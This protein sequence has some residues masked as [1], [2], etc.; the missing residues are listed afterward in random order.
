[1]KHRCYFFYSLIGIAPIVSS[2]A[3]IYVAPH[4]NLKITSDK[5]SSEIK[6]DNQNQERD[7][8][9][10]AIQNFISL[11]KFNDSVDISINSKL[12]VETNEVQYDVADYLMG[13]KDM[14]LGLSEAILGLADKDGGVFVD[15]AN[16]TLD[17]VKNTY[18]SIS[19]PIVQAV[20]PNDKSSITINSDKKIQV[21]IS[22]DLSNVVLQSSQL[23][24]HNINIANGSGLDRPFTFPKTET[25]KFT[26]TLPTHLKISGNLNGS[27]NVS[28]GSSKAIFTGELKSLFQNLT[29]DIVLNFQDDIGNSQNGSYKFRDDSWNGSLGANNLTYKVNPSTSNI[30]VKDQKDNNFFDQILL[31]LDTNSCINIFNAIFS[32]ADNNEKDLLKKGN[33][34]FPWTNV[35]LKNG[36][37]P[38]LIKFNSNLKN[39]IEMGEISR[40]LTTATDLSLKLTPANGWPS[41]LNKFIILVKSYKFNNL[42]EIKSLFNRYYDKITLDQ[43]GSRTFVAEVEQLSNKY[44]SAPYKKIYDSTLNWLN[45][46]GL[47]SLFPTDE[48]LKNNYNLFPIAGLNDWYRLEYVS[49][50]ILGALISNDL[51]ATVTVKGPDNSVLAKEDGMKIFSSSS[52]SFTSYLSKVIGGY[53]NGEDGAIYKVSLN[54]FKICNNKK[55]KFL[56]FDSSLADSPKFKTLNAAGALS[57]VNIFYAPDAMH[58]SS[59]IE[60]NW[61]KNKGAIGVNYNKY[62]SEIISLENTDDHAMNEFTSQQ[63]LQDLNDIINGNYNYVDEKNNIIYEPRPISFSVSNEGMGSVALPIFDEVLCDI[64]TKSLNKVFNLDSLPWDKQ[65]FTK[66]EWENSWQKFDIKL[67]NESK[68]PLF[69]PKQSD[70]I[71]YAIAKIDSF[72]TKNCYKDVRSW[73]QNERTK[74][75]SWINKNSK[76]SK[77]GYFI[78]K[79]KAC[80]DR[81][82]DYDISQKRMYYVN[83]DEEN[84]SYN[85]SLD[86]FVKNALLKTDEENGGYKYLTRKSKNVNG[87]SNW[88]RSEEWDIDEWSFNANRFWNDLVNDPTSFESLEWTIKDAEKLKTYFTDTLNQV[89]VEKMIQKYGDSSTEVNNLRNSISVYNFVY[90][91]YNILTNNDYHI[92]D[93]IPYIMDEKLWNNLTLFNEYNELKVTVESKKD[94]SPEVKTK[95]ENN[96][97]KKWLE[98]NDAKKEANYIPSDA[99]ESMFIDCKYVSDNIFTVINKIN[100]DNYDPNKPIS[101]AN[102]KY[103]IQ[104]IGANPMNEVYDYEFVNDNFKNNFVQFSKFINDWK[105]MRP[106]NEFNLY[107]DN[108]NPDLG[109]LGIKQWL[110]QNSIMVLY[111][112]EYEAIFD[113]VIGDKYIKNIV[114]KVQFKVGNKVNDGL[115]FSTLSELANDPFINMIFESNNLD[116]NELF[117]KKPIQINNTNIPGETKY[118]LNYQALRNAPFTISEKYIDDSKYYTISTSGSNLMVDTD[119]NLAKKIAKLSY[120]DKDNVVYP[121][122]DGDGKTFN[123]SMKNLDKIENIYRELEDTSTTKE[124]Y[125][126]T[127]NWTSFFVVIGIPIIITAVV[128]IAVYIKKSAKK[129]IKF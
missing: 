127:W 83:D 50:L 110:E 74:S 84:I 30:Y 18:S 56:N 37:M 34:G 108:D 98:D 29:N 81:K 35:E 22:D 43:P 120:N 9:N 106:S 112:S 32:T 4:N 40:L 14:G 26:A 68:Y 114:N 101:N 95:Y 77:D 47:K 111:N 93:G 79:L 49:Y 11:A 115:V 65:V 100:N 94:I 103:Y 109:P 119:A 104:Y 66:E 72:N 82:F 57:D 27:S 39:I 69:A 46:N 53:V 70:G 55:T 23:F 6:A 45:T 31:K 24:Q 33:D 16:L 54:N 38:S 89:L 17:G 129:K 76:L 58:Y 107:L 10:S 71:F 67:D 52:G 3:A 48:I 42:D 59:V 86:W 85:D 91:Y 63:V 123:E 5:T 126:V 7:Y 99:I 78:I 96:K 128:V 105:K 124:N 41:A 28:I 25:T 44:A 51:Y 15:G 92:T 117:I 122:I 118:E 102:A 90:R 121:V 80:F 1:M 12:N 2:L 73:F 87:D 19:K 61:T 116:K 125:E 64:S 88:F 13:A 21:K 20:V 62:L 8:L 97:F 113:E 36:K 60:S 75:I